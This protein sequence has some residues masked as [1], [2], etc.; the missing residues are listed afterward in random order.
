MITID[1]AQRS[2]AAAKIRFCLMFVKIHYW[3]VCRWRDAAVTRLYS[4][5]TNRRQF[6]LLQGTLA[7]NSEKTVY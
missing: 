2:G 4:A 3:H 7:N 1:E 6:G 5:Q